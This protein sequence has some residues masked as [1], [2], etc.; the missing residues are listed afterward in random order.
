MLI[1]EL[2]KRSGVAAHTI[3]FY[4]REGL[5]PR[6]KKLNR[7][8]ASYSEEHLE[9]L[10]AIQRFQSLGYPLRLLRRAIDQWGHSRATLER[11]RRSGAYQAIPESGLGATE[12]GGALPEPVTL[13]HLVQLTG[14][15]VKQ[16]DALEKWGLL[17]P[18]EPGRYDASDQELAATVKKILDEGV[19]L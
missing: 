3:N 7:T 15:S 11:L 14:L 9:W 13:D 1:G 18:R 10:E 16:V 8:R 19:S 4:V 17:R 6:P 5:L 2:S 12:S